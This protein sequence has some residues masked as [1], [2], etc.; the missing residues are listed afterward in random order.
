MGA[1]EGKLVKLRPPI[2]ADYEY[3]ASLK[4]DPPT[5]GWS[6][7]IPSNYSPEKIKDRFKK[8]N[9]KQNSAVYCI[10]AMDGTLIGNISFEEYSPRFC[11]VFGI[12]TGVEH[13]GKGYAEE[14]QEMILHY[15]FVERGIL[16]ARLWTQSGNKQAVRAADKLGFKISSRT[17]N[18]CLMDGVITD[19]LSMDMLREEY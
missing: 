13:W 16:V 6:Q 5:Q 8:V 2:E 7:R 1:L 17:R 11:A 4:N 12:A 14:A 19:N 10:E 3:L 18:G 9:D 15:L